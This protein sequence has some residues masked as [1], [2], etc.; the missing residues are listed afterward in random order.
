MKERNHKP[1]APRTKKVQKLPDVYKTSAKEFQE[2]LKRAC[3]PITEKKSR[4][5]PG[6]KRSET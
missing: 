6:S 3:Q 1:K 5:K 2:L 4:K